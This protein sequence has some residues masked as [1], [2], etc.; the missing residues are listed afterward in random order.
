MA[1]RYPT[2]GRLFIANFSHN[3]VYKNYEN[4]EAIRRTIEAVETDPELIAAE[5]DN[6]YD[7]L[8]AHESRGNGMK[9]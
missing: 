2:I 9:I 8:E 6:V 4:L 7:T 3:T 1:R 5:F